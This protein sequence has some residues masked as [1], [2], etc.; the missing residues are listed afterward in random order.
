[1]Q[2]IASII[3]PAHPRTHILL[4]TPRQHMYHTEESV[5][6]ALGAEKTFNHIECCLFILFTH[7]VFSK[8]LDWS[9]FCPREST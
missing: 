8:E 3:H 9:Y 7:F 6:I 1:M 4:L 2:S 5:V